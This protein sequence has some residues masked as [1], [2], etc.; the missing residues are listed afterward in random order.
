MPYAT[1]SAGLTA[2]LISY[3]LSKGADSTAMLSGV[4]LSKD[5]LEDPDNRI[6]FT[7]YFELMRRAQE[8]TND[9]AFSLHWGE[10]VG[11]SEVSI[12]GLIMNASATMGEA[13]LQ[14]Q[15][16]GSLAMEVQE[17]A[18]GPNFELVVEEGRLFMVH[19]RA[20]ANAFPELTENA[21]VRLVCGPRRFLKQPHVL[22]VHLSYPAPCYRG[23]YD[24][25]F[26]CPVHF[27]TK[28]NAMELHPEIAGWEV[29]QNTRYIFDLL[30]ERAESLVEYLEKTNTFRGQLEKE[31]LTVI[32][33]GDVG[34]D[35]IAARLGISRQ[36]MFRRLKDDETSFSAVLEELRHRLAIQYLKTNKTSVNETAYLT[37][38][39]E[40]A[41]F[42][43]AF[44]RW[45][46]T[47]PKDFAKQSRKS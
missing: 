46:G 21:F 23:E 20:E 22:S 45:T 6:P 28:W 17:E 39:S 34:A 14:L 36:T 43:R 19:Q 27:D 41:A 25:I 26:Q 47:S 30:T 7:C 10:D 3:A 15:R 4:G 8:L 13:F 2:G 32:H 44:K 40:P 9:P 16:F 31:L 24:R 5:E 11:M 38:F 29:A 1:V 12:V 37:G 35:N 33:K 18:E 42:S